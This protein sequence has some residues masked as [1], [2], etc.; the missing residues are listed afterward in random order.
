[1]TMIRYEPWL[2][3]NRLHHDLDRLF[4]LPAG[5][6]ESPQTVVD[7][8][9]AVDIREEDKQFILHSDLPGVDPKNIDI[10]L[11]KGVLTIRGRR[12]LESREDKDGYR[13]VERVSGEFYRRFS[14]PDT[15]DSQS[16]K[17]RF[18]NGVLEVAIP[19]QA[20]VLP[21]RINVEAA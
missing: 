1:M 18:T 4:N 12:E 5:N 2:L 13:R 19:K 14:L 9:P 11:E 6:D 17:A 16:V 20:Q 10:T 3:M 8:V 15:A 7:W 21:R